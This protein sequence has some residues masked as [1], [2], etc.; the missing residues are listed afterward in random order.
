M[1]PEDDWRRQGQERYLTGA[2]LVRRPYRRNAKNPEWDHDH[3]EFCGATFSLHGA[4]DDLKEGYAT[5]DDYRWIC[6]ACFQDFHEEFCWTEEGRHGG[7]SPLQAGLAWA[8]AAFFLNAAFAASGSV[9]T[10]G[11]RVL[12]FVLSALLFVVSF[13]DVGLRQALERQ[14]VGRSLVVLAGGVLLDRSGI[15]G[16]R[17]DPGCHAAH[18]AAPPMRAARTL[19]RSCPLAPF[20]VRHSGSAPEK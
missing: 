7:L 16:H 13:P 17:C 4:L 2:V 10:S 12:T 8:M 18:A 11:N 3:C 1:I 15:L 9:W 5:K 14:C 19:E 6:P 20:F